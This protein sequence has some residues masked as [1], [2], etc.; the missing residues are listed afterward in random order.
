MRSS[1]G[2]NLARNTQ[3]NERRKRTLW[4][5]AEVEYRAL[6][7]NVAKGLVQTTLRSLRKI[8]RKEQF[9][10]L[11]SL[12]PAYPTIEQASHLHEQNDWVLFDQVIDTRIH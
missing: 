12:R 5:L 3:L 4:Q 9:F 6:Q 2:F 8:S 11:L 10:C 1:S 7:K